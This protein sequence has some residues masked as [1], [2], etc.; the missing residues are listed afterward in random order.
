VSKAILESLLD[1]F[2]LLAGLWHNVEY[3]GAVMGIMPLLIIC[4]LNMLRLTA[5]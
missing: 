1:H 3:Y 2:D 4:A 5:S